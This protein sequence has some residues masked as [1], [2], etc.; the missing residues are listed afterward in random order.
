MASCSRR[1]PLPQILF[2]LGLLALCQVALAARGTPASA[3]KKE[4]E[5]IFGQ[6]GPVV[7]PGIGGFSLG[8]G[9]RDMPGSD[10]SVP[11]ARHGQYLPGADDTFVPNPGLEIPNPFRPLI[12]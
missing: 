1:H 7:I 8:V 12:P 11:A 4:T 9:G 3:D 2:F 10:H 6:E 5:T